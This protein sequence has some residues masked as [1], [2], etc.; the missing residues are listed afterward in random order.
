MTSLFQEE[1]RKNRK[2][3]VKSCSQFL[4][5][6]SLSP[7]PFALV[8]VAFVSKYVINLR[9]LLIGENVFFFSPL[10]FSFQFLAFRFKLREKINI[11]QKAEGRPIHT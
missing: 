7:T 11:P 9:F 8:K 10:F 6:K 4:I 1:K 5:L 3:K 2:K